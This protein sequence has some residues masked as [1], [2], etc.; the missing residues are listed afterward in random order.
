M[1]S[2]PSLE[3]VFCCISGSNCYLELGWVSTFQLQILFICHTIIKRRLISFVVAEFDSLHLGKLKLNCWIYEHTCVHSEC[4]ICSLVIFPI[5]LICSLSSFSF[6]RGLSISLTFFLNKE[7]FCFVDFSLLFSY[8]QFIWF[9]SNFFF[10][11]SFLLF[12]L[13][14]FYSPFSRFLR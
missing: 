13:G 7:I 6:P 10:P 12:I 14:L 5:V 2:F 8:F 3:P 4:R 9:C 11:L 1:Y